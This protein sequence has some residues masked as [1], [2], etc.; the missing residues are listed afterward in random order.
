VFIIRSDPAAVLQPAHPAL[1]VLQISCW[2][3]RLLPEKD[4][5][6]AMF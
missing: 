3:R 5:M 2:K 1:L 4:L 6:D